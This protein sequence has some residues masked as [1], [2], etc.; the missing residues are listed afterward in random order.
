LP[1]DDASAFAFQA[2]LPTAALPTAPVVPALADVFAAYAGYV[3]GLL[4][5][6]GVADADLE[7]VPNSPHHARLQALLA[8][9]LQ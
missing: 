9:S 1:N 6:L 8:R 2:P 5:R 7:D 4:R 3:L